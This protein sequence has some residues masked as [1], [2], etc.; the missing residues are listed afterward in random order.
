MSRKE[1]IIKNIKKLPSKAQVAV[2]HSKDGG[3]CAEIKI[4]KEV[5][6][7]QAETFP[8]LIG[9]VNDAIYT[10]FEIPTKYLSCVPTYIPPI[11]VPRKFN[12]YPIE[13]NHTLIAL[14]KN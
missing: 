5:L 3:F 13:W 14:T 7:T 2:I 4:G 6:K 9:M 1:E 11:D 8:E 10:Y 12:L